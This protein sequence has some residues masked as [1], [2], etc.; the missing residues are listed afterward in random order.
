MKNL[1]IKNGKIVTDHGVTETDLLLSDGKIAAIGKHCDQSGADAKIDASGQY[2]LPGGVDAH[3]HLYDPIYL[4]H[5]DFRTGTAAAA[6][7]G[8]TSVVEMVLKSPVDTPAR[9]LDKIS[10]GQ[11]DAFVDFS[12]H[13]GMMNSKNLGQIEELADLGI[14]SFKNFMCAPYYVDRKTLRLIMKRVAQVSGIVNVHAEDEGTIQRLTRKLLEEV[15]IDPPAH[16][17]SRPSIAE[18]KAV[19]AAIALSS[20]TGAH[21]HFS[22]LSTAQGVRLVGQAKRCG[23][24]VT[25]ETCPHY[26]TFTKEDMKKQGPYLKV[27]PSL[28]SQDD[29][30][31]LWMGLKNGAIDIVTSEHAPG[32]KEEKDIGW[33]NIWEAWSGLPSIET[34]LSVLLSEG[35]NKGKLTLEDIYNIFCKR[36][37]EIFGLYPRKGVIM[38]G[39]DADL[40]LVDLKKKKRVEAAN[41]HYKCGWTPYEGMVLTGWPT[42]VICRGEIVSEKGEV[43]GKPGFGKF[44]PRAPLP[45]KS[46][47]ADQ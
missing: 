20:L 14:M 9:V 21:L 12:L 17:E 40:T 7:G 11:R 19:S 4:N 18:A 16:P 30:D 34:M 13:A 23:V 8:I 2:V 24:N 42:L 35:V 3:A 1:L 41:L 6:A 33:T 36:P 43:S 39:S 47:K 29:V 15:R 32:T 10:V 28:K 46:F 25:A 45:E 5:E 26:L 44:I 38:V 22:H 31:T 37:A 27:N